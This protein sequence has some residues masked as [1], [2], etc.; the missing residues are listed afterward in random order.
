MP[1]SVSPQ[2]ILIEVVEESASS[3]QEANTFIND[4]KFHNKTMSEWSR[5]MYI[6]RPLGSTAEELREVCWKLID[7]I[8]MASHYYTVCS[9]VHNA[10]VT[11]SAKK[12][13]DIIS[14]LVDEYQASNRKRP[15]ASILESTADTYLNETVSAIVIAKAIKDFWKAKVDSLTEV[16][17]CTEH[18][19]MSMASEMKLIANNRNT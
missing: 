18:I 15:A 19:G 4:L 2:E 13:A 9:A 14:T 6:Q 11:G 17:K 1:S 16:R 12:K 3:G 5:E 7:H 10:L 8:Q